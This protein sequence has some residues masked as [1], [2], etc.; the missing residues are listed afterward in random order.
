M[1]KEPG[2]KIFDLEEALEKLKKAGD[3]RK[4][5]SKRWQANYD[6]AVARLQSRLL[7]IFE[8]NYLLG[9]I[10]ADSLPPLETGLHNGWRMVARNE[11]QVVVIAKEV[12]AREIVKQLKKDWKTITDDHANTPWSFIAAREQMS[13]QGLEWRASKD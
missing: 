13:P 7:Y 2:L 4:K 10:R 6:F 1:Q 11:A 5:E 8:Y 12:R 3:F 9:S